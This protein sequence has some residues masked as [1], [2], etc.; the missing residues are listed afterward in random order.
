MS[1]KKNSIARGCNKAKKIGIKWKMFAILLIFLVAVIGVIWFFQ[2]FML[3]AFYRN[4]KFDELDSTATTIIKKAEEGNDFETDVYECA[5]KYYSSITV[6]EIKDG[7]ARPIFEAGQPANSIMPFFSKRDM[8]MLYEYAFD[9]NGSYTATVSHASVDGSTFGDVTMH[10]DEYDGRYFVFD[11]VST[12]SAVDVRLFSGKNAE[13]FIVQT[14]DLSP[15]GATVKTLNDQFLW[16]GIIL[17]ILALVL[18]G[19]MSRLITK[20]I[21]RMNSAAQKLALGHYDADFEGKG[22]REIYELSQTLNYASVELAKTDKLQK[23]LISNVSHDLRTPLTMIKGYGEVMRD[24]PGENTPENVQVIIDET[25]RLAALVND[26][27]DVSKLQAGTRKPSMQLF[28]LTHAVSDTMKRYEK[29][30]EQYGYNIS[31]I[32]EEEV[33]VY[34]DSVMILQ[35]IYNLINNAINYTG[36]DKSVTVRQSV[37]DKKV[38]ISVTDTGEGIAKD[39]IPLIWD[40][41]YKVDKVHKRATV[42]TGLGLSITKEVLDLHGAQFGVNSTIGV[43][44]TF[45]FELDVADTEDFEKI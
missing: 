38:R 13:Y 1:G 27:L 26:L 19:I 28:S 30:T 4:A 36:E 21:I 5:E 20:P 18:A 8:L 35:V 34:A 15:V 3:D 16:I 37:S 24:I 12:L 23:E 6:F 7:I 39:D 42:G 40:R 11:D 44:S 2:V 41:Y 10:F 29:L 45:W 31:F 9:N 32:A 14:A 17:V 33:S 43:G 25:E 22:Y